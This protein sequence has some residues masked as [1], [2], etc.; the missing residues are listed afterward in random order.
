MNNKFI[1]T[2]RS[3][4]S[5][6][7][8]RVSEY[9]TQFKEILDRRPSGTR[10]RLA[11]ALG[12]NPSFISQISNPIYPIPIPP[13][14]LDTLFKICHFSERERTRFIET[15]RRAHPGRLASDDVI[16]R[17]RTVSLRLPDLGD[18]GRNARLDQIVK[19]FVEQVAELLDS[20]SDRNK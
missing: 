13:S 18:A 10:R 8:D 15:Y 5:A 17:Q 9:K 6:D 14:H 3:S 1:D 20:R 19:D 4:D 12:K 2:Q 16:S 11:A 7:A